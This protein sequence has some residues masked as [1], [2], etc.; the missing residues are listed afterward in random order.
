ML[1]KVTISLNFLY[2][3]YHPLFY[4]L[5][6]YISAHFFLLYYLFC[7]IHDQNFARGSPLFYS[8]SFLRQ[9]Q[10]QHEKIQGE[11]PEGAHCFSSNGQTTATKQTKPGRQLSAGLCIPDSMADPWVKVSILSSLPSPKQQ[12]VLLGKRKGSYVFFVNKRFP[13]P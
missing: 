3:L 4:S 6:F 13:C 7:Y 9:N 5:W 8:F 12:T 2:L 1:A 11:H 10:N